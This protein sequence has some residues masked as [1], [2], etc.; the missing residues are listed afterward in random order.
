MADD[1]QNSN[2]VNTTTPDDDSS[3]NDFAQV[4]D[5][6]GK[7]VSDPIAEA[8]K[9]FPSQLQGKTD[10]EIYSAFSD[11]GQKSKAG[12]PSYRNLRAAFPDETGQMTADQLA[13]WMSRVKEVKPDYA[14]AGF[15]QRVGETA[16]GTAH[17]LTDT[18]ARTKELFTNPEQFAGDAASSVRDTVA[19]LNQFGKNL[20]THPLQSAE[21]AAPGGATFSKDI[22]DKNYRGAAGD[23]VGGAI[24]DAALALGGGASAPTSV[25]DAS[26]LA[27][28]GGMA[29]VRGAE[30][31]A[32]ASTVPAAARSTIAGTSFPL[33]RGQAMTEANPAGAG[34]MVRGIEDITKG[35]PGG[36]PLR[37]IDQAQQAGARD[38][39]ANKAAT[40]AG[41]EAD[42]SPD[43]IERNWT[44]AIEAKRSQAAD[45]Y[46]DIAAASDSN[47]LPNPIDLTHTRATA[48][49]MLNDK[50]VA[51]LLPTRARRALEAVAGGASEEADMVAQQMYGRPYAQLA[52]DQVQHV[53]AGLKQLGIETPELDTRTVLNARSKLSDAADSVPDANSRRILRQNLQNFDDAID[54]TLGDFDK[55]NGTNLVTQRQQANTMWS[56]KY[57][58]Q[59]FRDGLQ[60]VMRGQPSEGTSR[61]VPGQAFQ[62]L[63]NK[64]DP[65]GG[66]EGRTVLQRMFPNDPQS[67]KDM[68]DLADFMGS[69]QGRAGGFASLI[70][71]LRL[72]AIP[73]AIML[74]HPGATGGF[75]GT[76][77]GFSYLMSR[78]GAARAMLDI[79]QAAPNSRRAVAAGNTLAAIAQD[80]HAELAASSGRQSSS[81][82]TVPAPIRGAAANSAAGVPSPIS[83]TIETQ[84]AQSVGATHRVL[85]RNGRTLGYRMQNGSYVPR[86]ALQQ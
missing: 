22:A 43:A 15:W 50:T 17:P 63:I 74:G 82:S 11:P 2:A 58:F 34:P 33:S 4:L 23:I 72:M 41:V 45:L 68:H 25:E 13:Q 9:R 51:P 37:D 24:S 66:R 14:P 32:R 67:V 3:G 55:K 1:L 36:Q 7:P 21:A 16:L 53:R 59:S 6:N 31:A 56:Q 54:T 61:Q 79:L 35:L 12:V 86:E 77:A 10:Q 26:K 60:S 44:N 83:R 57:A 76:S 71:K 80:A 39:L 20:V 38:V 48:I 85:D 18:W 78:P 5:A 52:P 64:L 62:K 29:P 30:A 75:L 46:D 49:A 73:A 81:S 65:P 84:R 27:L 47:A 19:G 8:R 69:N 40:A 70:G 42:A 28:R